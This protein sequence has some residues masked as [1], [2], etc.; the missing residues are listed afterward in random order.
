MVRCL[1]LL[2]VVSLTALTAPLVAQE[3]GATSTDSEARVRFEAG[4]MA[5]AAD[6]YEDALA[7]FE[8]AYELSH[9]GVLLFN[10]AQS[11]ARLGRNREAVER[12]TAF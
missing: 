12:Y 6:R 3:A 5:F 9:R 4:R 7:D 1:A 2:S 11:L 10:I 8:R